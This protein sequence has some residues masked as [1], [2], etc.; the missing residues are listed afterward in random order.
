MNIKLFYTV[1]NILAPG[2]SGVS[3][4][5]VAY[6]LYLCVKTKDNKYTFEANNSHENDSLVQAITILKNKGI[7]F[8]DEHDLLS[9]LQ[10]KE[11]R[12]WQY[13]HNIETK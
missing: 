8:L 4:T 9:C 10:N 7:V 2:A 11:V 1:Q 12:T 3:T 13:I 6:P 5:D